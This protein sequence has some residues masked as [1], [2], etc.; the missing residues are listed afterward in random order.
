MATATTHSE[1]TSRPHTLVAVSWVQHALGMGTSFL[2][3]PTTDLPQSESLWFQ[4][5]QAF[6]VDI[7]CHLDITPTYVRPLERESDAYLMDRFLASG[8]FSPKQ[9][10][11]LNYCQLHLRVTLLSDISNAAG[12]FI[13]QGYYDGICDNQASSTSAW[14][15][16]SQDRPAPRIWALWKRS[17][18]IWCDAELRLRDPLGPWLAL[19]AL[20]IP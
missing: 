13:D 20:T 5:L 16:I 19:D 8:W 15:S 17:L 7:D 9:I 4:S 1:R 14:H 6:L 12:T 3:D 2:R 18:R 10:R 11:Q